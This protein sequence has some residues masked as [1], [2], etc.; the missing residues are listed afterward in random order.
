MI[1]I[2]Q[3]IKFTLKHPKNHTNVLEINFLNEKDMD[4]W[5]PYLTKFEDYLIQEAIKN[6][7]EQ[8][9]PL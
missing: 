4:L 7:S 9:K 1:E 3:K 2:T 8:R 6:L 5:F